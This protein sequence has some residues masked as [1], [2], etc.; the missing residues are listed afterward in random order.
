MQE[1]EDPEE[2]IFEAEGDELDEE[3][4]APE[5]GDDI[6]SDSDSEKENVAE[7]DIFAESDS[8]EKNVNV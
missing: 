1:L 5:E 6:F 7:E 2:D 8:E 3:T 4:E